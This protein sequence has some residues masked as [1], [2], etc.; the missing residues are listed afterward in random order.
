MF[1][2]RTLPLLIVFLLGLVMMIQYFIPHPISQSFKIGA[3]EWIRIISA[4]ALVLGLASFFHVHIRKIM[5]K[6][7]ISI[8]SFRFRIW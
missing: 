6:N 2:K 3:E 7:K 4:F 1:L 8:F 5:R